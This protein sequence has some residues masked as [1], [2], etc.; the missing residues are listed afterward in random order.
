MPVAPLEAV[1]PGLPAA[2]P[3]L[4]GVRPLARRAFSVLLDAPVPETFGVR[5]NGSMLCR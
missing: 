4:A 2:L 1:K 5:Y 3:P